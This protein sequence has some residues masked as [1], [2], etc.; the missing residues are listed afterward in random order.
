MLSVQ[1]IFDLFSGL[2]R[3][4]D[5]RND[6]GSRIVFIHPYR[7]SLSDR[8]KL[9]LCQMMDGIEPVNELFAIDLHQK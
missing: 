8:F 1:E 7:M 5:N 9:L 3:K 6:E 4:E 2:I